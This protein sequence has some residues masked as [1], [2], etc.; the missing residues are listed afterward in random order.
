MSLA[1]HLA[2]HAALGVRASTYSAMGSLAFSA[3]TTGQRQALGT[4]KQITIYS[5]AGGTL[6]YR[7]SDASGAIAVTTGDT[8][9]VIAAAGTSAAINVPSGQA[10]LE[11]ILASGTLATTINLLG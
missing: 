9:L 7:F 4:A 5:A 2:E 1:Q 8:A 11:V 10:F 6:Y 3:T